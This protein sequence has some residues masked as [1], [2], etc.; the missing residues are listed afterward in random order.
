[1]EAVQRTRPPEQ[2]VRPRRVLLLVNLESRRGAA[3]AP[4]AER[5]LRNHGLDRPAGAGAVA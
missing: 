5:L 3:A 4:E 2:L 1:M